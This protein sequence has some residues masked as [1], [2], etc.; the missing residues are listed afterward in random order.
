MPNSV[1]V[2]G[3]WTGEPILVPDG[4]VLRPITSIDLESVGF[5]YWQTYRGT[6]NE[7]TLPEATEDIMCSWRGDYGQ[8]LTTASVGAWQKNELVGV[9]LTVF[10]A[11]WA[12]TPKSAFI[13]DLFV[14]PLARRRGIGRA[15]VQTAWAGNPPGISLR[16][17]DTAI[18]ARTLYTDLGFE[19]A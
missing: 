10:D 16:V 4:M 13:I 1:M 9:I 15:L 14:I 12:D 18:A 5:V 7:M 17:D 11:P 6:A 19:P 2:A 8:W 3:A